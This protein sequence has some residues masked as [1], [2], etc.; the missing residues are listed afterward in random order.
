VVEARELRKSWRAAGRNASVLGV[1]ETAL[2]TERTTRENLRATAKGKGGSVSKAIVISTLFALADLASVGVHADTI[3]NCSALSDPRNQAQCR[4]MQDHLRDESDHGKPFPGC[5]AVRTGR[6]ECQRKSLKEA[7]TCAERPAIVLGLQRSRLLPR[8]LVWDGAA[9]SYCE[10]EFGRGAYAEG[11]CAIERQ[12]PTRNGDI[13]IACLPP[14]TA[15]RD[16]TPPRLPA[17]IESAGH[18]ILPRDAFQ[19][20]ECLAIR[21][22]TQECLRTSDIDNWT[23]DARP[24]LNELAAQCFIFARKRP[25]NSAQGTTGSL[26][27]SDGWVGG[28][29][30][31]PPHCRP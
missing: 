15:R 9:E 10:A 11:F 12:T 7:W 24:P 5:L 28:G 4:L 6:Q 23:C 2:R 18:F 26:S 14:D 21:F 20:P 13:S 19:P 17:D 27:V 31:G 30:V 22:R 8:C 25:V 1:V 29:L 16:D 3:V